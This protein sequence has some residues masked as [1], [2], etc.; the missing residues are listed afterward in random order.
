MNTREVLSSHS[1][2]A[3]LPHE[4]SET[5][6]LVQGARRSAVRILIDFID[7]TQLGHRSAVLS[8]IPDLSVNRESCTHINGRPSGSVCDPLELPITVF[9]RLVV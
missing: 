7:Q 5:Q 1:T 2:K 9:R 6:S 3:N 8:V 4:E